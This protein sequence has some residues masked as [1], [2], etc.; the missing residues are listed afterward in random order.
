MAIV[1]SP[2]SRAAQDGQRFVLWNVG[3]KGYQ[4]LLA[5][6][7][8]SRTRITYDRGNVELMSPLRI[9]ERYSSLIGRMIETITQEL[10]IRVVAAGSTTFNSAMLDRGLEPDKCYYFASAAQVHDWDRVDLS[11]E[12]PPDL[13]VEID[14]TSS[15]LDRLGIYAALGVP[16][17]WR[18]DGHILQVLLLESDGAYHETENSRALPF[19]PMAELTR[20]LLQYDFGNDTRWARSFCEW[21]RATLVPRGTDH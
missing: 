21:V 7:G 4:S 6:V 18:F 1:T 10:D 12:P 9:H 17:V 20:F 16:E 15:S 8:N 14:I 11:I 19:V 5:T 2:K 13:A 3:W